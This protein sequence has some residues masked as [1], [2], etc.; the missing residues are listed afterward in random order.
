MTPRASSPRSSEGV[1]FVAR[2][3][4]V[5]YFAHEAAERQVHCI[6]LGRQVVAAH[7]VENAEKG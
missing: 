4:Q 3:V 5:Q 1:S 7:A 6:A 2:A